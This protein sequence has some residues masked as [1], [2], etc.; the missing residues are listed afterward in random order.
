[1]HLPKMAALEH[2]PK[3]LQTFLE[4]IMRQNKAIMAYRVEPDSMDYPTHIPG[5][6]I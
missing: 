2:D 3:I 6:H 5:I 1:M 4:K